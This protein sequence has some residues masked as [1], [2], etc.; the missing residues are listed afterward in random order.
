MAI[1]QLVI[2][3]DRLGTAQ[4]RCSRCETYIMVTIPVEE[5]ALNQLLKAFDKHLT[6]KHPAQDF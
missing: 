5:S 1:P 3:D 6:E 4:G 2:L